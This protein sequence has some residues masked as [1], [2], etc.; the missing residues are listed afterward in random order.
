MTSGEF[1]VR[2]AQPDEIVELGLL[3][4]RAVRGLASSFY[5]EVQLEWA[6]TYLTVPD[7]DIIADGTFFVITTGTL[8]VACGGWSTRRKLFTGSAE[9][10]LLSEERL[11][12]RSEPARIRSFF[13][14]PD[15]ARRGLGRMLYRSC[16]AAAEAAGYGSFELMATLP[17][18]PLYL[19][20]GF[21]PLERTSI[22]LPNGGLLPCVR[23]S[24]LLRL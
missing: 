9:Q 7:P 23:M 14:D 24:K 16:E 21:E 5:R 22:L 19:N 20:L 3:M 11:D 10:E 12:P 13:V 8:P 17:G 6:A 18:E 15:F 4:Q 1:K 2:L